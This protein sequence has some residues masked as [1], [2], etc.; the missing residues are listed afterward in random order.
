MDIETIV[1][2]ILTSSTI[3]GIMGIYLQHF[4][5]QKRETELRIQNENK[6]RY[7]SMLIWMRLVLSPKMVDHFNVGR[8]DPVLSKI[9]NAHEIVYFARQRLNEFYYSSVL[10]SP[11][12]VLAALKEFLDNPTEI[13]FVKTAIA[14]RKDL[15]KKKTKSD[16]ETLSLAQG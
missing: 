7:V 1:I 3:S 4:W 6:G 5:G 8:E 10:F 11:D 13:A 9:T 14:M 16:M 15:W 12:Y 2:S